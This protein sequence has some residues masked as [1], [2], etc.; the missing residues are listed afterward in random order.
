MTVF[1]IKDGRLLLLWNNCGADPL[2][3]VK[4]QCAERAVLAAAISD[5]EGKTWKGY[6]EI[7]AG[8]E[9]RRGD[10]QSV[11]RRDAQRPIACLRRWGIV[12]HRS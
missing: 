5:D 8:G 4:W 3:P 1:R 2:P 9:A 10:L 7:G 11:R 12:K 6:R